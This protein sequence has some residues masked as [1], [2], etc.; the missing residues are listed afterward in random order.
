MPALPPKT[1]VVLPPLWV[2]VI[3][4]PVRQ[5]DCPV[6]VSVKLQILVILHP[7]LRVALLM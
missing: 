2:A 6:C 1:F 7:L 5:I 3:S 4:T